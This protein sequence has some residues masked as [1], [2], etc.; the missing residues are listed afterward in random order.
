MADL[1]AAKAVVTA[2]SDRLDTAAPDDVAGVLTG[3]VTSDY[4]WRG[5]H[6]WN[7][8]QDTDS[9]AADV[10]GPLKRAIGP[11]QRRPD[12][13][14][15]GTNQL[16]GHASVWVAS[17]GHLMG[18][19]DAP[20][21]DVMP[22]RKLAFLRY[23][24]FHRVEGDRIAETAFYPDLLHLIHQ[25]GLQPFPG[26]TGAS[27]T[28]PGP[29]T[30]DGLLFEPQDAD[31]GVATQDLI[32]AMVDD[33]RD[34]GLTSSRDHLDRFWTPDMCWFGPAGIGASAFREG[35]RRGHTGPFED[36]LEFIRSDGHQVEIVEGSYGGFFGYPS[37]TLRPTGGFMGMP[38]NDA[39]A[40]MR[41]VDLYRREGDLLAENWIFIDMLHFFACQGFDVLERLKKH[42][43]T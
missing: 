10:W 3:S 26:Q 1:Q 30:H 13:F 32:T 39:E 5:V 8:R 19:W 17:M 2:Y 35:Y 38:A 20:F 33:L 16:D 37:I 28:N 7:E 9:I 12:I 14:F 41:L 11:W 4:H 18:T 25:A 40:E 34:A 15:A 42:K 27:I 22:T 6:P 24:E 29:R 23:A 43:R 31:E 21:L 36:G